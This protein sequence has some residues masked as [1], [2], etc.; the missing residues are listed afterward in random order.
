MDKLAQETEKLDRKLSSSVCCLKYIQIHFP[1]PFFS[2]TM[3]Q[4]VDL[5]RR[6]TASSGFVMFSLA[7]WIHCR[8]VSYTVIRF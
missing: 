8:E 2:Q 1:L 4:G 7:N 5:Q 3:Q 6:N